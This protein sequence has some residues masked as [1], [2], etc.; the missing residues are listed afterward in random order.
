M[1]VPDYVITLRDNRFEIYEFEFDS[2]FE[3]DEIA[4]HFILS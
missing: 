3:K 2:I 1:S 4:T